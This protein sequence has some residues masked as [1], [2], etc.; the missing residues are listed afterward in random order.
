MW[1]PVTML[2]P[3][4]TASLLLHGLVTPAVQAGV[5][6]DKNGKI[7]ISDTP[8]TDG[9][10]TAVESK[11]RYTGPE[12]AA[13]SPAVWNW[14][15]ASLPADAGS[16]T[17]PKAS[18]VLFDTVNPSV[19]TVLAAPTAASL[20]QKKNVAQGSAVAISQHQL[21]TNCHVVQGRSHIVIK[22]A[23]TQVRAKVIAG[24]ANSDRCILMVDGHA[25]QPVSGYR[26]FGSLTIGET[27]YTVGS[28]LGLENTL[29]HGLIS[30]LREAKGF[31]L[32]QTTAQVSP[33]SSGGG[34]F[35]S[36]GNLIGITTFKVKNSDG[37]NFAIAA[38]DFSR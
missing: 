24:D 16:S 32:V 5:Y 7:R 17:E 33:G 14:V 30:G 12:V 13:T 18:N 8:P 23:A 9:E 26:S 22:H 11:G 19:W 10:Y 31:H 1:K 34:L 36:A 27:V 25:L 20:E 37:L 21:L 4:L 2:I 6:R 35:D 28:P 29:G 3:V 15:P 38:E